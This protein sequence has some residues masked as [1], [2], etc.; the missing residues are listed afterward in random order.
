MN[1]FRQV[2]NAIKIVFV[3]NVK[4]MIMNFKL[5]KK[6]ILDVIAQKMD[7]L[8]NIAYVMHLE[9]NVVIY[10]NVMIA[11][12]PILFNNQTFEM[13]FF[14]F[15]KQFFCKIDL[16]KIFN[17]SLQNNCLIFIIKY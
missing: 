4:I 7:A 1:V 15:I 13:T 3:K 17:K 10:A 5:K 8:K 9:T 12:I 14:Y 16:N 11:K 6:L 2:N